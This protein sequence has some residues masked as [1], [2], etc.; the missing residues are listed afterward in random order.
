MGARHCDCV[1]MLG[2]GMSGMVDC[3]LICVQLV[4]V[5][6]YIVYWI[7]H[8]SASGSKVRVVPMV[9]PL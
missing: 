6:F 1:H 3:F 4:I 7:N 9:L 8:T 5:V 2:T